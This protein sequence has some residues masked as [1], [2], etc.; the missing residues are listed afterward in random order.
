M[1]SLSGKSK[2]QIPCFPCAVATLTSAA[3]SQTSDF[4]VIHT[5]Y[6]HPVID[7]NL[8]IFENKS[9][10]LQYQLEAPW[11]MPISIEF[12]SVSNLFP[13]EV[14]Q[15]CQ[16]CQLCVLQENLTCAEGCG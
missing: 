9:D 14:V 16:N 4:P 11:Y 10:R 1:F 13:L 2:N 5:N 6:I 15:K 12:E 8:L 3:R 7:T